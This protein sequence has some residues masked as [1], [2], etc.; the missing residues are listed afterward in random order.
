MKDNCCDA[1]MKFSET[2]SPLSITNF[3]KVCCLN[4]I[5]PKSGYRFYGDPKSPP[6]HRLRHL[7]AVFPRS[8]TSIQ[9]SSRFPSVP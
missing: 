4:E 7:P 1:T 8:T 3:M 6:L 5:R 2:N 9:P